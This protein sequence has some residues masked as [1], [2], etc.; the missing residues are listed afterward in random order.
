M[1]GRRCEGWDDLFRLLQFRDLGAP[2]TQNKGQL[3]GGYRDQLGLG[4]P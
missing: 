1:E 2:P 3:D 4:K